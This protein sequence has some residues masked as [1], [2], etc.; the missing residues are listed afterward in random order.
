MN[1][2]IPDKF[3]SHFS[4][5]S[6]HVN[7]KPLIYLD[8][9]A[10]TQKPD[11]V[12]NTVASYYQQSNANVHRASHALSA[13]A[14]LQ[15]EQARQITQQFIGAKSTQ[16]VIWTKGTTESINLVASCLAVNELKAGDQ[17][18]VSHSEH[19]ANIV[20]WQQVAEQKGAKVIP[21]PLDKS[22]R[23]DVNAYK[24]LLNSKV[25]VVSLTHMSNVIA[26]VNPIKELISLAKAIGAYTLV[27]GAQAIAHTQ[28]DVIELGCDFYVFSA[29]KVYGP[30]GVGVLYGKKTV[31]EKLPPYQTG[32]EMIKQVS[33][34]KTTFNQLPFKFEA[35]TPNIAGVIG[36]GAALTFIQQ[37]DLSSL[38][39]HNNALR[40]YCYAA[41]QKIDGLM[42]V[43]EEQPDAPVFAF[44]IA[45]QHN[46]DIAATLDAAG[47]AV[48]SGHHCAMP[49]MQHL[50]ISG[51]IRISFSSYNTFEEAEKV[52][53]ILKNIVQGSALEQLPV[54]QEQSVKQ[55]IRQSVR[56]SAIK[57]E[58]LTAFEKSRSWDSKHRQIMLFGKQLIRGNAELRNKSNLVHGCE[59]QAWIKAEVSSDKGIVT[60]SAD[61]DAKIIRGLMY[62]VLAFYQGMTKQ[63]I[64]QSN[65]DDYFTTLGLLQHLSPSRGNGLKGIVE[66]IKQLA[67]S[68]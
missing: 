1:Q 62:I 10:T 25:K 29:H 66:R 55:S 34:D 37:F 58:V 56:Q 23:I 43:V 63:E 7:D 38:K 57:E 48:R 40:D 50:N 46:H 21:V 18:L 22:G 61:S 5:L 17:I 12:I 64:L 14:T 3:R 27:D 16:E 2:A 39:E 11:V 15:F 19:H 68:S 42:F 13:T 6:K 35:G 52:I 33:F 59:S 26:K 41:L 49:L 24:S 60:L 65:I 36:F 51:C 20:P 31:L 9:A 53:D 45:N 28:V 47:I 8:N 44:T 67:E 30:T 32:G 4:I 54:E